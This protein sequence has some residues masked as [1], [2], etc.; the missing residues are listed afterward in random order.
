MGT[1]LQRVMPWRRVVSTIATPMVAGGSHRGGRSVI[2]LAVVVLVWIGIAACGGS[3]GGKSA[4]DSTR[5]TS[6]GSEER[7]SL[8]RD[9]QPAAGRSHARVG[10]GSSGGNPEGMPVAGPHGSDLAFRRRLVRFAACLRHGGVKVPPTHLSSRGSELDATGFNVS[11]AR[12][13]ATWTR[14][15]GAIGGTFFH[16]PP[17]GARPSSSRP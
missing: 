17:A 12:A 16:R 3:S 15:R 1:W 7:P 5:A 9:G 10:R 4:V 2:A 8:G 6:T 14:C 13:R 11:S